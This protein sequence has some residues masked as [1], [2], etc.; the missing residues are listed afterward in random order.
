MNNLYTR[1]DAVVIACSYGAVPSLQALVSCLPPRFP[2]AILVAYHAARRSSF[3]ADI[4][5]KTA[6]MPVDW[7][8][9]G[10]MVTAGRIIMAVPDYHLLVNEDRTLALSQSERLHFVRPSAD[11]LFDSAA[12]AWGSRT[13]G[14]II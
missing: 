10:E 13:I 1:F 2:A 9:H 8:Q 4:L 5:R 7:A 14:I 11:L 6:Q 12:E 3:M